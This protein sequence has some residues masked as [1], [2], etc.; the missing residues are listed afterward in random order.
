MP[1]SSFAVYHFLIRSM[2]PFSFL[3]MF[4]FPLTPAGA[5]DLSLPTGCIAQEMPIAEQRPAARLC[6]VLSP[7]PG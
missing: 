6:S 2:L 4:F 7:G 5:A 3:V 1:L